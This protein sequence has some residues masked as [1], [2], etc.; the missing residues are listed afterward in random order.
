MLLLL[1]LS[2]CASQISRVTEN[3][4]HGFRSHH[5]SGFHLRIASVPAKVAECFQHIGTQL[6]NGTDSLAAMQLL[7]FP[8]FE[9][10]VSYSSL[11][12]EIC[13]A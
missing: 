4:S 2:V 12:S 1:V 3:C 10:S 11:T 9:S 5:G 6:P 8:R 13:R 7:V